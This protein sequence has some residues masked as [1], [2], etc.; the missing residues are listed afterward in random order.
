M[1]VTIGVNDLSSRYDQNCTMTPAKNYPESNFSSHPRYYVKKRETI[2]DGLQRFQFVATRVPITDGTGAPPAG[3]LANPFTSQLGMIYCERSVL[4]GLI[5]AGAGSSR[6]AREKCG[7][8]EM[9]VSFCLDDRDVN[10]RPEHQLVQDWDQRHAYLDV[11][12]IFARDPLYILPLV[13]EDCKRIAAFRISRKSRRFGN[14]VPERRRVLQYLRGAKLKE[15]DYVIVGYRCNNVQFWERYEISYLLTGIN[16]LDDSNDVFNTVYGKF[17]ESG[18]DTWYLCTAWDRVRG[19]QVNPNNA[20]IPGN[21]AGSNA[22]PSNRGANPCNNP[23]PI[24]EPVP[25][26]SNPGGNPGNNPGPSNQ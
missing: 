17:L 3:T 6:R 1:Q 16:T 22:C 2:V 4:S 19:V 21:I 9:L 10:V 13:E 26:P 8:E 15:Y 18:D 11:T 20:V 5:G 23:A 14:V 25:G 7:I 12:Q 24:N